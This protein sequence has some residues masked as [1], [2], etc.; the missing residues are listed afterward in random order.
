MR[1]AIESK[2]SLSPTV[3]LI[4][5]GASGIGGAI[6]KRFLQR[7]YKVHVCDIDQAAVDRFLQENSGAT[8]TLADVANSTQ[9]DQ[10]FS[11]LEQLYGRL[12][13]LVNNAGIAGPIA[14]VE[15][16]STVDWDRTLAVGLNGAFYVTRRA[17]PWLKKAGGGSIIN[18][19]SSAAFFGCPLRSPYV[20]AKW[21]LLG[22]TKTLAM[23]LGPFEIR[24]NAICPGSVSGPRIEAVIE[25]DAT[26]RGITTEEVRDSW[27]RQTS[28]RSFVS[29][30][31]VAATVA[32][33]VSPEGAMIS[34]QALGVDGH[35]ESLSSPLD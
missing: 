25:R 8:A 11:D 19:A 5:A 13:I 22:F 4:T 2:R 23:E 9:V 6:A 3:A 30:D 18:M 16:I 17:V 10:L 32:F 31:D 21:A 34:G 29:A 14:R 28:L 33:L 12:D 15:D 20:A 7:G 26:Q 35:T 24:V 27:T 1:D